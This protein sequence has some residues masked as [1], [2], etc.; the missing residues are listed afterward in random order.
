MS[1]VIGL[2]GGIGSGKSTAADI[3]GG[4]GATLIDADEISRALTGPGGAAL[5]AIRAAFGNEMAPEATGV[6]RRALRQQVFEDAAARHRLE[7]IVHPAI[8]AEISRQIEAASG[9]YTVLVVPLF[10][11]SGRYRQK[12][13]R[14]VVVDCSEALQVA[15]ASARSSLNAQEVRAIMAAQWPRWRRLQAAD[16]VLWNGGDRLWLDAQCRRLHERLVRG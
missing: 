1:R 3:L 15:R 11:E 8:A 9:C 12:V 10:F 13:E 5:P 2:T 16:E 7:A 14:V 4:L 6:D